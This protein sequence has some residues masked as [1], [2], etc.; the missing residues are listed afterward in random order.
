MPDHKPKISIVI[1][2]YKQQGWLPD[3]LD[4]IE[5]QTYQGETE[6][7]V[8][9]DVVGLSKARNQGLAQTT[10]DKIICLDADDIL[11]DNYIEDML[12]L[13]ADIVYA[14]SQCFGTRTDR[15]VFSQFSESELRRHNFVN[16]AAMFNRKVY[17]TIG[18]FDENMTHGWEDY[19]FWI[20]ACKAGFTFKKCDTTE[21][22]WRRKDDSMTEHVLANLATIDLYLKTKHPDFYGK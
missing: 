11:A 22:Y 7:I 17:E 9:E 18:G 1:P 19:E 14:D 13:E 4:S 21:L 8:I 15:H 3:A 5:R 6:V 20:R 12:K 10:G 16:C 2:C